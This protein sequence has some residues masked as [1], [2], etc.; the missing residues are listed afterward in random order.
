MSN[1][2]STSQEQSLLAKKSAQLLEQA[3]AKVQDLRTD[4]TSMTVETAGQAIS[5]ASGELKAKAVNGLLTKA[6]TFADSNQV[7]KQASSVISGL[8]KGKVPTADQAVNTLL[9]KAVTFADSNQVA[10]QASSVLSGLANGQVPTVDQIKAHISAEAKGAPEGSTGNDTSK[11]SQP[12]RGVARRNDSGFGAQNTASATTTSEGGKPRTGKRANAEDKR[13]DKSGVVCS[14]Q[15]SS[16]AQPFSEA[17]DSSEPFPG[18]TAAI[19]SAVTQL[20]AGDQRQ[21]DVDPIIEFFTSNN[22]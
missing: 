21:D 15:L 18:T 13:L 14:T 6:T 9:T 10:K 11:S 22:H 5:S 12:T 8:T 20:L 3:K 7:V 2:V 16:T 1:E 19:T 17:S 4:L